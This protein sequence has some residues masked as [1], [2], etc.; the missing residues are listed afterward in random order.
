MKKNNSSL[1]FA[2][3]GSKKDRDGLKA[4]PKARPVGKKRIERAPKPEKPAQQDTVDQDEFIVVGKN[5]VH[6][7]LRSDL[8]IE[9]ILVM[10][11]NSDHVLKDLTEKAK[12]RGLV[13]QSV[14]KAK[15]EQISEGR[16]HQGIAALLAPFPYAD[17]NET[18]DNIDKKGNDGLIVIL[19]HVTDPHNFGAVVRNANVT[20]ADAV[21]FPKRR[22]AGLSPTAVKASSGAA[23]HTPLVK[24]NNLA[25]TVELLKKRGYWIAGAD[26]DGQPYYKQNMKGK[27][28]IILGAEGSGLSPNLKKQ[29]DFNVAI[30]VYGKVDSMNVSAAAAVLL[31]EAARQRHES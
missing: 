15:L 18:L 25:Q 1:R 8:Q 23:A 12:K 29:C 14:D 31:S 2:K 7:A 6:E 19:D 30:P 16:P 26:M 20:G 21:V 28:A 5:P 4:K 24:V 10:K 11:D 13:V 17:L 22:S 3:G 27:L 9:K